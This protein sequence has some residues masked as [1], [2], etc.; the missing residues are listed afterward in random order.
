MNE[1]YSNQTDASVSKLKLLE[2]KPLKAIFFGVLS[3]FLI[4]YVSSFFFQLVSFL[5]NVNPAYVPAM[6][7]AGAATSLAL[8]AYMRENRLKRSEAHR[9]KKIEVYSIFFDFIFDIVRKAKSDTSNQH[10]ESKKFQDSMYQFK[11]Q[12]IFYGSPGVI[13][14][15]NKFQAGQSANPKQKNNPVEAVGNIFIQ[16]RKDIGLSNWGLSPLSIQEIYIS[17]NPK[18]EVDRVQIQ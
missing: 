2:S 15:F 3:V 13:G 12:L 9:A 10:L 8:I 1:L 16:M 14:A 18:V 17:D 7:G 6:I 11:R 5:Y 4:W